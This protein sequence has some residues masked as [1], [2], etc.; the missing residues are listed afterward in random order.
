MEETLKI[1]IQGYPGSFHDQAAKKFFIDQ[2]LDLL[3]AD[4]FDILGDQLADSTVQFAVMAIEN[5]IAGTILQNYRILREHNFWILGE[6]YLRIEH[7]LLVN[8]GTSKSQVKKVFSHPMALNQCLEFLKTMPDVRLIESKDTALSAIELAEN[9]NP[10]H[11]CIASVVA[12]Q[13]T[14]LEIMNASIETNKTNYTRFFI[15][16]KD[17]TPVSYSSNKAT[18]YMRIPDKKGQLLKVLECIERHD[19]NMS[20]LQSFPVLGRFREYFFHM[21]IEFDVLAQY[22]AIKEE[23]KDLTFEFT[24]LGI[25]ERA[26][27][28]DVIFNEKMSIHDR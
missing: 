10:K 12:A 6:V 9:P 5:S 25:Y 21:D 23:L 8:K 27:L 26:D 13:L 1:S 16:S 2:K 14:G 28:R 3:P 17:K 19:L 18:V 22:E 15:I 24:E 7:N 20:K 4:S 11:A